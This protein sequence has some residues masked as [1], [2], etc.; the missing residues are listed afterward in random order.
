MVEENL[1]V[2]CHTL[3]INLTND[4]RIDIRGLDGIET[5]KNN[6][7]IVDDWIS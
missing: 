2:Y 1:A 7:N 3:Q 6:C 4:L 5:G